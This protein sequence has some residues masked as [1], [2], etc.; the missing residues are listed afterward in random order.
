MTQNTTEIK[1]EE[2]KIGFLCGSCNNTNNEPKHL[3]TMRESEAEKLPN[4]VGPDS[5]QRNWIQLDLS[6]R[7]ELVLARMAL[8]QAQVQVRFQYWWALQ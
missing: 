3:K 4:Q 2:T 6:H 1:Q 7:L 5:I 8:N